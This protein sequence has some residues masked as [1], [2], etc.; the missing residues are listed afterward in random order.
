MAVADKVKSK[1]EKLCQ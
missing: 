1:L